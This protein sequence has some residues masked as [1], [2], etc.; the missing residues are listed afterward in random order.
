M[1]LKRYVDAVMTARLRDTLSWA[2]A[3]RRIDRPEAYTIVEDDGRA[4]G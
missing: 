4:A 2:A 3:E 1:L